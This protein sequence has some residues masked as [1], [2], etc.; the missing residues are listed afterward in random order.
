MDSSQ[1][2]NVTAKTITHQIILF[3]FVGGLCYV[4]GMGMLIFLVEVFQLEVNLANIVSSIIAIYIA[5]ILNSQYIFQ[6]GRYSAGREI[7]AFY[8]LSILGLIIN[9][10]LMYLM[11]HYTEIWYVVSKT[12]I[13]LVV[14]AFNFIT[15][16]YFVFSG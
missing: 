10:A 7:M 8:L 13:T 14:A 6:K 1:I 11:T 2:R 15:R 9:I 12:G 3:V 5:Y 4:A 16:K